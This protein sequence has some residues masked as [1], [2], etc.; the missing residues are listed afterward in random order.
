MHR[1]ECPPVARALHTTARTELLILTALLD[2]TAG[3][4]WPSSALV[5]ACASD[6]TDREYQKLAAEW[7]PYARRRLAAITPTQFVTLAQ[8]PRSSES[9]L[10]SP[11][12]PFPAKRGQRSAT[13]PES[14]S[15]SGLQIC[16]GAGYSYSSRQRARSSHD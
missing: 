6:S 13:S 16:A 10:R 3:I 14:G 1:S 9:H 15:A 7:L 5:C 11:G 12:K 8:N 2:F 4:E